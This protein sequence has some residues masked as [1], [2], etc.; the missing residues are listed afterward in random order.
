[1]HLVAGDGLEP[2][3]FELHRHAV[4][5][6]EGAVVARPR[7]SAR[8]DILAGRVADVVLEP[9]LARRP[10][11]VQAEPQH[12][13]R[14]VPDGVRHPGVE[15]GAVVPAAIAHDAVVVGGRIGEE[16]EV[17]GHG[18]VWRVVLAGLDGAVGRAETDVAIAG[19]E[20]AG[21]GSIAG[22]DRVVVPVRLAA[23]R[24]GDIDL[25]LRLLAR[26]GSHRN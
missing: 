26:S 16:V 7:I 22:V 14:F 17:R 2:Q 10:E 9:V 4:P 24:G 18:L 1:M 3:P 21:H 6:A 11:R 13:R 8:A 19:T 12:V 25:G 20:G 23:R 5:V 15:L